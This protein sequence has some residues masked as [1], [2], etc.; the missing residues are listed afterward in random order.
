MTNLYPNL[1]NGYFCTPYGK[2]RLK[3]R[4]EVFMTVGQLCDISGLSK[5]S[6]MYHIRTGLLK[7]ER[8]EGRT[9]YL[10]NVDTA[11]AYTLKVWARGK[12]KMY[13]PFDELGYEGREMFFLTRELFDMGPEYAEDEPREIKARF[14]CLGDL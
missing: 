13:S 9:K 4:K 7:P 1:K 2:K 5:M 11:K 6:V 10:I 8:A 3:D 12:N 14:I